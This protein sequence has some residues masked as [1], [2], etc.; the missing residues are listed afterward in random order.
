MQRTWAKEVRSGD[1]IRVLHTKLSRTAKALKA[2]NKQRTR[3][4]VFV[5]ALANDVIFSLDLA[6]EERE[7]STEERQL[8]A[9]LKA[10]LLGLAAVDRARWRQKS[11]IT[12]IREGMPARGF[13]I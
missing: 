2:W 12:E 6:Q 4:T 11:R 9:R 7:L 5:L 10:K 3:W 13:S 1:P 8:R